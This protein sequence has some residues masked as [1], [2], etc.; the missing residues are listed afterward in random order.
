MQTM[1]NEN[2][3]IL[4]RKK[5]SRVSTKRH[6]DTFSVAL[7]LVLFVPFYYYYTSLTRSIDSILTGA[8]I[9]VLTA[10]LDVFILYKIYKCKNK[11]DRKNKIL[12]TVFFFFTA[13]TYIMNASGL[14]RILLL[15]LLLLSVYMFGISPIRQKEGKLLFWLYLISVICVLCNTATAN[16]DAVALGKTNPNSGG[17]LLAILFC[18]ALVFFGREKRFLSKV[19]YAAICVAAAGLQFVYG[20]R[21]AMFGLLLFTVLAV[22]SKIRKKGFKFKTVFWGMLIVAVLGI[23]TAYIYSE[24]LFPLL[25]YGK[26]TIFGKD[27][28]TGRQTIWSFAFESIRNHLWF[29][30]GSHLNEQYFDEG[31]YE[32]IMNAHNQPIGILAAFG[33]FVFIAFYVALAY[34]TALLYKKRSKYQYKKSPAIYMVVIMFMSWFDI[35]FMSLYNLLPIIVGYIIIVESSKKERSKK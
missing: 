22:F 13:L 19:T 5:A 29:G 16:Q 32:L 7:I 21:T 31:Y 28:F 26:V 2:K 23:I 20:S 27:L 8:F 10:L 12:L 35:Y 25:G 4:S 6:S 3:M 33:I 30:V 15:V 18:M 24:V 9:I 1:Y 11:P 17:F 14:Q 34:N